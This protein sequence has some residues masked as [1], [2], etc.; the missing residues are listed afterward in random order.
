MHELITHPGTPLPHFVF[1]NALPRSLEEQQVKDPELSLQQLGS[2]PGLKTSTWGGGQKKNFAEALQ[3][4]LGF[5][6]AATNSPCRKHLSAPTSD[7]S[8]CLAA[9]VQPMNL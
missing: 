2:T 9:R 6:V 4:V 7:A 5:G 8:V 3:G 1:K